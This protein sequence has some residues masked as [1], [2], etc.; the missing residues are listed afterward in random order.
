MDDL[1]SSRASIHCRKRA[2]VRHTVIRERKL[3]SG[4]SKKAAAFLTP[5]DLNAS[6][7]IPLRS[8]ERLEVAFYT[9]Q[10]S[11]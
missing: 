6:L 10:L 9:M 7:V 8:L 2:V 4:V 3:A 5:K 1:D 11:R